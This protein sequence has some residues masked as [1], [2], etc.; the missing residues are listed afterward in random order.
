MTW[1]VGVCCIGLAGEKGCLYRITIG[2][3]QHNVAV[4]Q[5]NWLI[6]DPT[7]RTQVLTASSLTTTTWNQST[8]QSVRSQTASTSRPS[9]QP[10]ASH[11]TIYST[12]FPTWPLCRRWTRGMLAPWGRRRRHRRRSLVTHRR[13]VERLC[14]CR[15]LAMSSTVYRI[16]RI[17]DMRST[18]RLAFIL[19]A[20]Y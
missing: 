7:R 5:Q 6:V 14:L 9:F 15:Y 2:A 3:W 17:T 11:S 13:P 20:K 1:F 8:L 10:E 18:R 4:I 12:C 19:T 16:A